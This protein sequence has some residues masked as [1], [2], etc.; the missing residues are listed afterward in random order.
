MGSENK[1]MIG[2]EEDD[3]CATFS[4]MS[5]SLAETQLSLEVLSLF[6]ALLVGFL[7]LTS[8]VR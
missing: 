4:M 5:H 6:Y 2:Q 8:L 7:N 3:V 1:E